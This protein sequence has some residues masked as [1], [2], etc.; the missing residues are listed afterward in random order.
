MIVAGA[1][2]DR[3]G[4]IDEI[5]YTSKTAVEVMLRQQ[6]WRFSEKQCICPLCSVKE[7]NKQGK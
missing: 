1:K 6:G 2:C 3:C 5:A 4:R 7:K